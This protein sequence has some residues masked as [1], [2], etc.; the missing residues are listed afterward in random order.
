MTR[1]PIVD[2]P[3][4]N[5]SAM[6]T[7]MCLWEAFMEISR[8]DESSAAKL[9]GEHGSF[10]IRGALV[11]LVEACDD[12]WQALNALTDDDA[13]V[14]DWEWCPDF[15]KACIKNGSMERALQGQYGQRPKLEANAA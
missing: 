13:P 1:T 6:V 15:L 12:G 14:F 7:G 10:T 4:F 2:A 11:D 8:S 3:R 5:D 9:L